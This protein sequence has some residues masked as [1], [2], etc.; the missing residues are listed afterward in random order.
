ME[1]GIKKTYWMG[2]D[3]EMHH[4]EEILEHP[5]APEESTSV[6]KTE[7]KKSPSKED[8]ESTQYNY[9][10]LSGECD[11]RIQNQ[12]HADILNNFDTFLEETKDY[13]G[14][15]QKQN[16]NQNSSDDEDCE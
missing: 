12:L 1:P 9:P 15:N 7:N 5:R 14:T 8:C 4:K 16:K 13:F 2:V 10:L 3:D 11:T 6:L